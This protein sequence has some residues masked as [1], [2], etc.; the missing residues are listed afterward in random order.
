MNFFIVFPFFL[1]YLAHEIWYRD[2]KVLNKQG[3]SIFKA[4]DRGTKFL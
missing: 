1:K 4:E 2:M 3:A